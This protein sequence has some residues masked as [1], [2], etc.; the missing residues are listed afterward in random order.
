MFVLIM[1]NFGIEYVG[2]SHLHHL[3]TVLTNHYTQY[4]DGKLF[5]GIDL[6]WNYSKDHTQ[7]T[8]C[9]SLDGYIDKLI[10]K[11]GHKAPTKPQNFSTPSPRHCIRLQAAVGD[12][13]RHKS[14]NHQGRNKTCASYCRRSIILCPH[15]KFL[16]GISMID[17]QHS[18]V[19]KKTT[20]AIDQLLDHVATYPNDGITQQ[21]ID[22]VLAAQSDAGI[23]NEYKT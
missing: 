19:T 18:A 10:L 9:L 20:A 22:M 11:F 6:N 17:A 15:N 21:A 1:D 3:R 12:G 4:L 13:G 14:Q 16:V 23:N 7:L 5:A 8:C 2:D